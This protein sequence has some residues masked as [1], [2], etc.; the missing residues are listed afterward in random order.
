MPYRAVGHE[1]LRAAH[2]LRSRASRSPHQ[3]RIGK[4][5]PDTTGAHM[6]NATAPIPPDVAARSPAL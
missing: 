1:V 2:S 3:Q 6:L 5:L 4:A